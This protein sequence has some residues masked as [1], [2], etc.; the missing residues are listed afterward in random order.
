MKVATLSN[1]EFEILQGRSFDDAGS[2]YNP[3][4][5]A[6][7]VPCITEAEIAATTIADLLWVKELPLIEF[8]PPPSPPFV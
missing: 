6:A 4:L 3:V 5:N 7:G 1:E 8:T 2:R